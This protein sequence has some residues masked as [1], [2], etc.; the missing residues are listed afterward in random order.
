MAAIRRREFTWALALMPFA[1]RVRASIPRRGPLFWQARRGKAR[2]F[3]LAFGD[4]K[5]DDQAWLTPAIRQAFNDSS[6]LWLEVAPPEASAGRDA[7]TKARDDAEYERLSHAPPGHSFFDELEPRAR[8]RLLPYMAELGVKREAIEPLRPWWAYYTINRVF[9]AKTKLPYESVNVDQ[10]LWKLATDQGKSIHYENPDG[11]SFARH[12][13]AMPA[14]AQSQYIEFLLNFLDDRKKRLDGPP[15]DWE[16][17]STAVGMRSLTRMRTELPDLYQSIQVQRNVWWA[18]K[19]DELL[20]GDRISFIG[21]GQ[22]H[23]IGPDSIP[24][25][26]TRLKIVGPSQLRENPSYPG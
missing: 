10:V 20:S 22:L 5:A 23:C 26:L 24:S 14:K 18:H 12:M 7:A 3:L 1:A 9:W 19:I 2:V 21:M 13:A 4:A 6:E 8:E 11:V 17:G 16:F 15:F 25:Q